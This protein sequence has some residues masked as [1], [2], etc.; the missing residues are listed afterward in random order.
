MDKKDLPY[1]L[2]GYAENYDKTYLENPRTIAHAKFELAL[3]EKYH[4]QKDIVS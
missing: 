1:A 3:V 4:A 2:D